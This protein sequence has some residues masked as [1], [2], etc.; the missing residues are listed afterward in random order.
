[1]LNMEQFSFLNNLRGGGTVCL[2]Q[3]TVKPKTDVVVP[4][5]LPTLRK[6]V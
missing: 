1:M 2:I 4:V 5:T 6:A 3:T